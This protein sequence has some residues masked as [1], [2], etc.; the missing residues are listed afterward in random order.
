MTDERHNGDAAAGVPTLL[1][2]V[3][4]PVTDATM[5]H[6]AAVRPESCI[7]GY[8]LRHRFCIWQMHLRNPSHRCYTCATA[9]TSG[10]QYTS[11]RRG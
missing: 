7:L 1:V 2:Q 10:K 11:H 5:L 9:P 8:S 6:L 3:I 4:C